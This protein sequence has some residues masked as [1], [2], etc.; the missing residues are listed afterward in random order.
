MERIVEALKSSARAVSQAVRL[1]VTTNQTFRGTEIA[2]DHPVLLLQ[3]MLWHEGYHIGL[4]DAGPQGDPTA[5]ARRGSRP[6]H[7]EP[8][9]TRG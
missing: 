8:L 7:V 6:G 5:D 4:D 1:G 3:H 2:Y 9:A